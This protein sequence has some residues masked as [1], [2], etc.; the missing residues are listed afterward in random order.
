MNFDYIR[1]SSYK[2]LLGGWRVALLWC[3]LNYDLDLHKDSTV[4]GQVQIDVQR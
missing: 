2:H 3:S 1:I 4:T